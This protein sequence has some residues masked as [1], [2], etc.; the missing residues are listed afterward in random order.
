MSQVKSVQ[1][2]NRDIPLFIFFVDKIKSFIYEVIGK[3]VRLSMVWEST[4]KL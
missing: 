2:Q 3:Q 4:T 1:A